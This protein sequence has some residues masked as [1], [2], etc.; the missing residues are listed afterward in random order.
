MRLIMTIMVRDEADVIEAM[1]VHHI[2]Q[3]IDKFI[4]TD[5][6]SIDGT[7][8]ILNRYVQ[9]GLVD[10]RIDPVHR[11]Q[12]STVV[13]SMARDAYTQYGADWVINAD[14][15]EFWVSKSSSHTVKEALEET[16]KSIQSFTVPVVDM[17][18]PPARAGTGLNRLIYRDNR[19]D[20]ALRRIGLFAGSTSVAVHV[21]D[22]SVE[23]AQGN[24]VVSLDSLGYPPEHAMIEVLHFSWRSWEQFS[25]KVAN[26]GQ[27]Y[28]SNPDLSPSPNHHGMR[29]Y[30]RL[31]DGSLQAHYV[32]RHPTAQELIEGLAEG[33][34]T[35][36]ERISSEQLPTTA[37]ELFTSDEIEH[38]RE[39]V[40]ASLQFEWRALE[41][42]HQLRTQTTMY[43]NAVNE[44][45]ELINELHRNNVAQVDSLEQQLRIYRNR[46]AIRIVDWVAQRVRR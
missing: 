17:T 30:A 16:S 38:L 5:N 29:D 34:Y 28:E 41:A 15:D 7:T 42:E 6:G 46:R 14:A 37:D 24:H 8:S 21:G 26:A 10:L 32:A 20:A 12:Q 19:T 45:E 11:K 23:V 2:N 44:Y 3:G 13:T 22:A 1:I 25:R 36:T 40:A 43:Q 4:V 33:T 18:G 31:R 9:A 35:M 27:A 39:S